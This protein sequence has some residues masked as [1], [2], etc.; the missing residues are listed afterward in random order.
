ML[1]PGRLQEIISHPNEHSVEVVRKAEAYAAGVAAE[2]ATDA[3]VYANMTLVEIGEELNICWADL[4][5]AIVAENDC[6]KEREMA[7]AGDAAPIL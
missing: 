6:Q 5:R 1:H 7:H 3:I 2:Y 4:L